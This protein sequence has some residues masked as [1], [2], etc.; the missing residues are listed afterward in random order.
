MKKPEYGPKFLSA[1]PAERLYKFLLL[2]VL[3]LPLAGL[4]M[5]N[6]WSYANASLVCSV[7]VVLYL[8][9]P[10]TNALIA[11]RYESEYL[12]YRATIEA[13]LSQ[14]DIA[15]QERIYLRGEISKLESQYHL[16]LNPQPAFK[17]ARFLAA[18]ASR[19]A[20]ELARH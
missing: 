8:C 2:M 15:P 9:L 5:Q 16:V 14:A 12:G 20:R 17:F 7:C 4:W 10:W 3:L 6:L 1:P 13:R 19:F 11:A 18:I